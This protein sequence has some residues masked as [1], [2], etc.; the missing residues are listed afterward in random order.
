MEEIYCSNCQAVS[1]SAHPKLFGD[2]DFADIM[3]ARFK[4][5][6]FVRNVDAKDS[7]LKLKLYQVRGY[8][9]TIVISKGDIQ[10]KCLFYS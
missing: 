4:S 1:N 2:S 10:G 5:A 9:P 7:D 6:M 3:D 8:R